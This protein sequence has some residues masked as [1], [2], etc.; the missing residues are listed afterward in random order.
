MYLEKLELQSSTHIP[1]I[2]EVTVTVIIVPGL[3]L[4]LPTPGIPTSH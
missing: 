2:R 4:L 3:I 1:I